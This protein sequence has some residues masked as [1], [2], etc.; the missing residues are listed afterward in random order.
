MNEQDKMEQVAR[1]CATIREI[2]T[3]YID[4]ATRNAYLAR[5]AAGEEI[6]AYCDTKA[7]KVWDGATPAGQEAR[8]VLRR[9]PDVPCDCCG[10]LTCDCSAWR[11][12][13]IQGD[14]TSSGCCVDHCPDRW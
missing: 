8:I 9:R 11:C 5:A 7:W 13:Q 12:N 10:Q 4:E 3:D 2:P 6:Y 1:N 14:G